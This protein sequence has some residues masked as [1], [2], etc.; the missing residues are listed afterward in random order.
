MPAPGPRANTIRGTFSGVSTL[1]LLDPGDTL[2][3]SDRD[4]QEFDSQAFRLRS[5]LTTRSSNPKALQHVPNRLGSC[6]IRYG[7]PIMALHLSVGRGRRPQVNAR[8][9]RLCVSCLSPCLSVTHDPGVSRSFHAD[10][11][12]EAE[13]NEARCCLCG[14]DDKDLHSHPGSSP[15]DLQASGGVNQR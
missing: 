4:S 9:L 3:I 6:R 1:L 5:G 7:V 12:D 10:W 11:T 2:R 8:S 14:L 15:G 13:P